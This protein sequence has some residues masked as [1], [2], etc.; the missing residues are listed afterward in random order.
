MKNCGVWPEPT[1]LACQRLTKAIEK[2]AIEIARRD[3]E[4]GA[5]RKMAISRGEMKMKLLCRV[6]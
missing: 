5:N 1:Q 4:N 2:V 6:K 3:S